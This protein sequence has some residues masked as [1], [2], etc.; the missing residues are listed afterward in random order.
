MGAG[1]SKPFGIPTMQEL[2]DEVENCL[3]NNKLDLYKKI[4]IFKRKTRQLI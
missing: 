1:A 2:T 3:A 4:V